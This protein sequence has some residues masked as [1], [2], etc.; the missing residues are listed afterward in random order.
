MAG[1]RAW[2]GLWAGV[3]WSLLHVASV[4]AP[5]TS[6]QTADARLF[7]DQF[8]PLLVR[9]CIGCHGGEKPKGK[10]RLDILKTEF[11][12]AAT[13]ARWTAVIDRVTAG[14]MPPK[15]K[16]RLPQREVTGLT[17]WLAASVC[18]PPMLSRGPLKEG[19]STSSQSGRIR[20][21]RARP[22][23]HQHQSQRAVA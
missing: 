21:Y 18:P 23:G 17:R 3:G 15:G 12:D 4:A 14:E 6:E 22:A 19:D 1:W 11:A 16:P 9:H 10:F 20:E 13:R 7:D 2:V 8:R 5:P